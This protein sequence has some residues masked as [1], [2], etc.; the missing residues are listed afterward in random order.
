MFVLK[1]DG[2]GYS[3]GRVS[4][5]TNLLALAR[6]DSARRLRRVFNFEQGVQDT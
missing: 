2:C 1:G 5:G 3:S 6:R 4:S